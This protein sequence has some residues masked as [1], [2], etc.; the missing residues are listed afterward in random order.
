MK[1]IYVQCQHV[2]SVKDMDLNITQ[3]NLIA[4]IADHWAQEAA[5]LRDQ[6]VN[7]SSESA[8]PGHE[9][10][11]FSEGLVPGA[12]AES[13]G[14]WGFETRTNGR[15]KGFWYISMASVQ[16]CTSRYDPCFIFPGWH[17]PT[18][19]VF[20]MAS[21]EVPFLFSKVISNA[22]CWHFSEPAHSK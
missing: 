15:G 5:D 1:C 3:I 21:I 9:S 19:F 11:M 8:C 2:A 22:D 6:K 13:S 20:L 12:R 10:W 18:S 4:G 17:S 14:T 7:H 16:Q